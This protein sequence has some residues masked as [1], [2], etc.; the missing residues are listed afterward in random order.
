MIKTLIAT[1]FVLIAALIA[2][3]AAT[4]Q[5]GKIVIK[6][7]V[8]AVGGGTLTV[9]S[10]KG[11]SYVISVPDESDVS[12]IQVGDYVLVK[13]SAGENGAWVA[14]TIKEYNNWGADGDDDAKGEDG[15]DD[16]G[17]G[18]KE[19]FIDNSAFCAEGKHEENHPLAPKIAERLGETE[20]WVMDRFC[21][22][23]SIGAIMLAIKTSQ[24]D[25]MTSSPHDLLVERAAGNGWGLIWKGLGLIGCKKEGQSPP[26][27]LKKPAFARPK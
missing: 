17:M 15:D 5:P 8:K 10:H 4:A 6:G 22:G 7:E 11:G 3:G 18:K 21:E 26:G 14:G 2:V 27:L 13:A 16:D 24:M 9:E 1:V 12:S 19:G 25:G 23:Y 20:E